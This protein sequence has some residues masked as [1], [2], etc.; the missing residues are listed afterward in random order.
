MSSPADPFGT[1]A[2]PQQPIASTPQQAVQTV[3]QTSKKWKGLQL[4][5]VVVWLVS[6]GMFF[7]GIG[8]AESSPDSSVSLITA[9]TFAWIGSV[10][11]FIFAKTMAWWHHA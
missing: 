5:S 6:M 10:V 11:L 1:P 3:E 2:H 4:I 7:T 8:M 9:S